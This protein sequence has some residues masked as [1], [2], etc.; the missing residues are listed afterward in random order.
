[1]SVSTQS[2]KLPSKEASIFKKIVVRRAIIWT[3]G[4]HVILILTLLQRCYEVKQYKNGLKFARQILSNPK[5]SE[6]G[7]MINH[8][9]MRA[10]FYN[11]KHFMQRRWL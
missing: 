4:V 11:S 7:G 10:Y 5:F 2:Q 3:T 6:H 1:M 8:L 9:Q